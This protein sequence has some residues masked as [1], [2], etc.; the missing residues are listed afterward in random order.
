MIVSASKKTIT[1]AP[2]VLRN[3]FPNPKVTKCKCLICF[4]ATQSEMTWI[5]MNATFL[6]KLVQPRTENDWRGLLS[7]LPDCNVECLQKVPRRKHGTTLKKHQFDKV[8]QL[9]KNF[10][11]GRNSFVADEMGLGKTLTVLMVLQH[12]YIHT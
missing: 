2:S 10:K 1:I 3:Y 6:G 7:S 5:G 9:V 11:E 4:P 12:I 8:E